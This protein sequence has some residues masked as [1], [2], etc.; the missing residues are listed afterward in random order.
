MGTIGIDPGLT[1]TAVVVLDD[2]ARLVL[3]RTIL[4]F[5][6]KT[7]LRRVQR[8]QTI[9]MDLVNIFDDIYHE[10]GHAVRVVLEGYSYGSKFQSHQL[11]ELG[12][13]IRRSL[14]EY[15]PET[16]WIVPPTKIKKFVTGMGNAGK[17]LVAGVI[18]DKWGLSF[19]TL[20]QSDACACALFGLCSVTSHPSFS[21][22][23][24]RIV[25]EFEDG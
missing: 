13:V 21:T 23:Q 19:D 3:S 2:K 10:C 5:P 7:W 1:S 22:D 12:Y 4:S 16:T 20:D 17:E 6:G 9:G 11:G 25:S 14:Y 18:E 8:L 24:R 15:H